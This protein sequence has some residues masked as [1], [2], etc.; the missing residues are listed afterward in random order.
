MVGVHPPRDLPALQ[1]LNE[2]AENIRSLLGAGQVAG[3]SRIHEP[4]TGRSARGGG[5]VAVFLE[6]E[7]AQAR[8]VEG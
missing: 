2:V 7:N 5:S 4:G 8:S 3:V 1:S 6:A